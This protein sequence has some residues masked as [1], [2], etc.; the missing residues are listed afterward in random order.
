MRILLILLIAASV[1]AEN[2][3][4]DASTTPPECVDGYNVYFNGEVQNVGKVTSCDIAALPLESCTLYTLWV[5]AYNSAGESE[6]SNTVTYVK[7]YEPPTIP[8]NVRIET[9]ELN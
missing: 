6:P 9:S 2:L 8:L 5:T 4:W 3:V 1:S 7:V